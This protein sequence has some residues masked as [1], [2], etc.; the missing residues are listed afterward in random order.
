MRECLTGQHNTIHS[1]DV[2]GLNVISMK[3]L[4]EHGVWR[5]FFGYKDTFMTG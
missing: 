5:D 2:V 3:R 4:S 1:E